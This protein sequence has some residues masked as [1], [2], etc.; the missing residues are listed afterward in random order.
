MPRGVRFAGCPP[1]GQK[2]TE[3]GECATLSAGVRLPVSAPIRPVSK[4]GDCR[5]LKARRGRFESDAGHQYG[6]L[7]HLG[8]RRDGI[9]EVARSKLAR[10]TNR[11]QHKGADDPCKIVAVGALPTVST[12]S[13]QLSHLGEGCRLLTGEG[14][15]ESSNWSQLQPSSNGRT[16]PSQGRSAGS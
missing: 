10:S 5:A 12:K 6:P 3:V 9:A 13:F 11:G 4:S 1:R 8:E 15:F 2:I 16:R 14:W 7:A